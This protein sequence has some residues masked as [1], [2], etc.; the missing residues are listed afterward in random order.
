[1]SIKKTL[2]EAKDALSAKDPETALGFVD[3]ALEEDPQ[4]YFANVFAG[5]CHELMKNYRLACHYYKIATTIEPDNLL[6]WKGY[7]LL[8]KSNHSIP[9]FDDKMSFTDK[10]RMF[11]EV[12]E[13]YLQALINNLEPFTEVVREFELYLKKCEKDA[14][15]DDLYEYYLTKIVPGSTLYDLCGSLLGSPERNLHKLVAEVL[16][17][18]EK[19]QV[20]RLYA[21][22]KVKYSL[23]TTGTELN[24]LNEHIWELVLRK[25]TVGERYAMLISICDSD[26]ERRAYEH[27]YL[28]Y[29]YEFLIK[30][31]PVSNSVQKRLQAEIWT[32]VE[33]MV[34][35]N[36]T[37]L[38]AWTIYWDWCDPVRLSDL[39]PSY[40][41]NYLQMY[42]DEGVG[43]ILYALVMSDI[44][45]FDK[46]Q[47]LNLQTE[48]QKKEVRCKRKLRKSQKQREEKEKEQE[49]DKDD[50]MEAAFVEEEEVDVDK[51][52]LTQEEVLVLLLDGYSKA[53]GSILANRIVS[54]YYIHLKEFAPALEKTR[55]AISLLAAMSR[56]FGLELAHTKEEML[57]N[58]GTIYTFYEAPKNFSKAMQI[59]DKVL[60]TNPSNM[61]ARVGKGFILIENKDLQSAMALFEDVSREYPENHTALLELSWCKIKFG[62]YQEGRDGLS[63]SLETV[64]GTDLYSYERRAI[65]NWRLAESYMLEAQEDPSLSEEYSQTSYNYLIISLKSLK[66]YAP[67]YTSLGVLYQDFYRDTKRATKCFYKAFELDAGEVVSAHY[68]VEAFSRDAEWDT[69]SILSDRVVASE[70]ARRA[71]LVLFQLD[72]S[73]P[74]RVLGVACLEA[75]DNAKA[76]EWFQSSLRLNPN[77]NE[78]WIGLGEA[79]TGCGRL[80]SSIKVFNHSLTLDPANWHTQY[81]LGV[82]LNRIG[83]HAESAVLLRKLLVLGDRHCALTA[84]YETLLA[85]ASHYIAGGFFGRAIDAALE[86]TDILVEVLTVDNQSQAAWK[87]LADVINSFLSI[88]EHLLKFPFAKLLAL[89]HT[90]QGHE[91]QL[92]S[93]LSTAET[94]LAGVDAL[95]PQKS[96]E[97]ACV[98]LINVCSTAIAVLPLKSAKAL[99]ACVYF[100]LGLA[101]LE[102]FNYTKTAVYRDSAIKTL[103]KAITLETNNPS[104]WTALGNASL[105]VNPRISQHCF[106]KACTYA[107]RDP[108]IW[109]NLA[110]LYL[111]Y[112]D[113]DLAEET[114]K[115]AQSIAP[116]QS[117]SWSG[118]ALTA[119]AKGDTDLANRLSTHSYVLSNG[120]SPLAHLLF[121]HTIF[122]RRMGKGDDARDVVAGQE[123][124]NAHHAMLDY[125]KSYPNDPLG[126][127]LALS[128]VER[129]G[130]YDTGVA[131]GE[132]L[133]SLLEAQYE[134]N[135]SQSILFQIAKVK[136]QLA[137]LY[138]GQEN[139]ES[140]LEHAQFVLDICEDNSAE[141]LKCVLSSRVVIGLCFFFNDGF[142]ESLEQL[143]T[144]LSQSPESQRLVVLIAQILYAYNDEE[145]KQAALDQLFSYIEEFG[146]SL[147]VA[148][149][150]GAICVNE[151]LA[152]YLPAIK[153]ELCNLPLA[154]LS[155][156][157]FRSVPSL[158][159][160]I[161]A[162]LEVKTQVWQRS[163]F[164]FPHDNK[165]WAKL[166]KNMSLQTALISAKVHS[167]E[168]SETYIKVGTMR[169]IQRGLFLSPGAPAGLLALKGCVT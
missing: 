73:W 101:Y 132:K 92:L 75:Q 123:L 66:N 70:K 115:R 71:L 121:G 13:K 84:L 32:M 99:R 3:Q 58:L 45:T 30:Y 130:D 117:Q 167:A 126:L 146:S 2:K 4:N 12:T 109:T 77:D 68:L 44:S 86:C 157:S 63:R 72:P 145:T 54:S 52:T 50:E 93:D 62:R 98:V 36:H 27:E 41:A 133:S 81:L 105:S 155:S 151:N 124:S 142:D 137:R 129:C 150:I 113:A 20:S 21:R 114:F 65:I 94:S 7:F 23:H 135:D 97:A 88:Q 31:A 69:A 19:Q 108:V 128:I 18:R 53:S 5:K 103:R 49:G 164:L 55:N 38:L 159:S 24:K 25:S 136:T 168:L 61:D 78:S 95:L 111:R 80:E 46:A 87:A 6:C 34:V 160:E 17:P 43:I 90:T 57:V 134:E 42:G 1:M 89:L 102:A 76:I 79:Y 56:S 67:A 163:G 131:L 118:H 51:V 166:D 28:Q 82:A 83:E 106:I 158:L 14:D 15:Y 140:A 125:L 152:D 64:L 138:L 143:K 116:E 96:L 104:F 35:V 148:L 37:S 10:Y 141:A 85:T 149:T 48:K 16:V 162:R 40:L 74:Y 100:N 156:D 127:A 33:G 110:A 144:I 9:H 26:E 11:F 59:F 169:E 153:E 119:E 91:N 22:E 161:N 39:P 8:A 112:G 60:E 139:F 120:R 154:K 147:M 47:I 122:Q 165:I 29:Q 107:P